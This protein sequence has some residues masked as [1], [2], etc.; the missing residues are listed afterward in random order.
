MILNGLYNRLDAFFNTDKRSCT[1]KGPHWVF[2]VIMY[3]EKC[4]AGQLALWIFLYKYALPYYFEFGLID[5]IGA[6]MGFITLA[7]FTASVLKGLYIKY[8]E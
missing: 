8:I 6:L 5:A 4:N 3:C 2:M 1:S 7:I